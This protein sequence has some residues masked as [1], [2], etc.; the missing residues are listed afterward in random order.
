[1]AS[2]VYYGFILFNISLYDS[3]LGGGIS[4]LGIALCP[5]LEG[6]SKA[7]SYGPL[8]SPPSFISPP[9]PTTPKE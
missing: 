4:Q 5:H 1:M 9:P 7:L 3:P 8:K 2:Q 6:G